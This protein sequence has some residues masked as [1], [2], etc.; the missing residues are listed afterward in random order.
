MTDTRTPKTASTRNPP[1]PGH[2]LFRGPLQVAQIARR[3]GAR[4]HLAAIERARG[5]S[6]SAERRGRFCASCSSVD[7]CH[8]IG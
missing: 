2:F 3:E 4:L 5:R 1:G 7:N 8:R 6:S